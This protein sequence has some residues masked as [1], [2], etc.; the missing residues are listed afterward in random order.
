[1]HISTYYMKLLKI[2]LYRKEEDENG[3]WHK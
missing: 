2:R 3:Q 1:V